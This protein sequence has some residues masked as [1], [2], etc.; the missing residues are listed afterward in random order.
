MC[1]SISKS[2]VLWALLLFVPSLAW[3]CPLCFSSIEK[4]RAA[5][6]GTT[7]FLSLL[8]LLFLGTITW[9]IVRAMRQESPSPGTEG[10]ASSSPDQPGPS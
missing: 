3:A 2:A 1:S 7:V 8:P 9:W 5:Y 6:Q 10:Q 4:E